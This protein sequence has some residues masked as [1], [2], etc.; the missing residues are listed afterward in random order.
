[1][2]PVALDRRQRGSNRKANP[3][4]YGSMESIKRQRRPTKNWT[5]HSRYI[6]FNLSGEAME[7]RRSCETADAP[8]HLAKQVNVFKHQKR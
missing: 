6:L 2:V 7:S 5:P 8:C 1:M 4:S 3:G